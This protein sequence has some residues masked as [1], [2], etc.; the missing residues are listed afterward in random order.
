MSSRETKGRMELMGPQGL[1]VPLELGVLLATL[2]K[3]APGDHKA[4]R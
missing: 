1:L 2:G 3:M 4:Q